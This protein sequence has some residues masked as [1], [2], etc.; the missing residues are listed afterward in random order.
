MY[1]DTGLIDGKRITDNQWVSDIYNSSTCTHMKEEGRRELYEFRKCIHFAQRK[2]WMKIKCKNLEQT[3]K[4]WHQVH[5]T[6]RSTVQLYADSHCNHKLG[7]IEACRLHDGKSDGSFVQLKT[8]KPELDPS[9]SKWYYIGGGIV[10]LI[11]VAACIQYMECCDG[12]R[13][14]KRVHTDD[15]QTLDDDYHKMQDPGTYRP[16]V[17]SSVIELNM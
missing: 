16:P 15:Y 11:L 9:L 7:N 8:K 17:A 2:L 6:I 13:K 10:I 5:R 3:A 1:G 14:P 12:G 4:T